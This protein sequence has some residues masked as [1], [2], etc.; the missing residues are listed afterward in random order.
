MPLRSRMRNVA[1]PNRRHRASKKTHA[2]SELGGVSAR[3]SASGVRSHRPGMPEKDCRIVNFFDVAGGCTVVRR[4]GLHGRTAQTTVTCYLEVDPPVIGR[5]LNRS[6][7]DD[8]HSGLST[9]DCSSP[10]PHGETL[11]IWLMQHPD[12]LR[13][14]SCHV[15]VHSEQSAAPVCCYKV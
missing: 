11:P 6:L 14:Q 1:W 15:Q 9:S 12:R 2:L 10:C 8:R 7:W 3:A 4:R 5:G 13:T